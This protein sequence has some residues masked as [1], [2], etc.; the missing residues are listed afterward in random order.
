MG[1][2]SKWEASLY[3]TVVQ[4]MLAILLSLSTIVGSVE[5]EH[6]IVATQYLTPEGAIIT[7][8]EDRE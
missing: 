4:L 1:C 2:A 8:E 3:Q 5:V 6:G 7:I